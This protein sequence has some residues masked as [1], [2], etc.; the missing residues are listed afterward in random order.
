MLHVDF[1]VVASSGRQLGRWCTC[2]SE[3]IPQRTSRKFR[4]IRVADVVEVAHDNLQIGVQTANL[5]CI[6][7][8]QF[9]KNIELFLQHTHTLTHPRRPPAPAARSPA[10]SAAPHT[11]GDRAGSAGTRARAGA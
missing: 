6:T 7:P 8:R 1:F 10:G 3:R 11:V 5:N 2:R 4:L 9:T